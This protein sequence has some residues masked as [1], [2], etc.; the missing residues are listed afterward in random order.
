MRVPV[1]PTLNAAWSVIPPCACALVVSREIPSPSVWQLH[2]SKL[3][4]YIVSPGTI[5]III[6]TISLYLFYL[7]IDLPPTPMNPCMPS[8]CGANAVCKDRSGAGSC[9]CRPE[10]IGNPYEGCRPECVMN[11]DCAPNLACMNSRCRDPCLGTCASNAQCQVI[12]HLPSCTCMNGFSGDPF[13][14]CSMVLLAEPTVTEPCSPS[15]CGPNSQ[16]RVIN[17]QA[18]CSCLQEYTGS[19][20][21]CRPECTSSSE[22]SQNLACVNRK[23]VNPCPAPCGRNSECIVRNH[24][25]ICSCSNGFTGNPFTTCTAMIRELLMTV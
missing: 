25:P 5:S 8:P 18:V 1:Q 11:S 23:C 9:S 7:P 17:Q 13:Q 14:H 22:C 20:P 24:N 3:D 10:Y 21:A 15:P 4:Q 12:N 2:V 16:C 19:P 6:I